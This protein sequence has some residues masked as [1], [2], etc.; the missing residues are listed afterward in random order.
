MHSS[1]SFKYLFA[2]YKRL[3]LGSEIEYYKD[4]PQLPIYAAPS[5]R[6]PLHELIDILMKPDIPTKHILHRAA[7]GHF[8]EWCICGQHWQCRVQGSQSWWSGIMEGTGTKGMYFRVMSSGAIRF[9]ER[10]P[11]STAQYFLLTQRYFVHMT[12][13]KFHW[14]IADIWSKCNG[15][16]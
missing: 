11:S 13:D 15:W 6:M 8:S 2:F 1:Q 14:M 12:Y 3:R 4:D 5:S 9:L 7:I 16:R 10:K